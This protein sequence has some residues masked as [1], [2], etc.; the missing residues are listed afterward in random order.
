M[1]LHDEDTLESEIPPKRIALLSDVHG[2]L[3]AFQSVLAD[4]EQAG[5]DER[6]C[7]GDLVGYG[8]QPDE[9][10]AL[11]RESCDLTLIGNHDLV[12]IGK[13][14]IADFS[15]NAAVAARWT[16]DH[17]AQESVDYLNTLEPM[18]NGRAVGLAW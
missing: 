12:V 17:I 3:P 1:S 16:Q 15:L 11:A 5:V 14:D 4:I 18:A 2:N 6:W 8:A 7:L 13:L 9:C 10:V